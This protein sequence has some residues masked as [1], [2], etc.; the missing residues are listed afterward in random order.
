MGLCQRNVFCEQPPRPRATYKCGLVC[1]KHVLKTGTSHYILQILWAVITCPCPWCLLPRACLYIYSTSALEN[2]SQMNISLTP[3]I[4]HVLNALTI[5][6]NKLTYWSQAWGRL[7]VLGFSQCSKAFL[8]KMILFTLSG[9][10]DTRQLHHV[11]S[12]AWS[13]DRDQG[14]KKCA[15]A[16]TMT[17]EANTYEWHHLSSTTVTMVF[18]SARSGDGRL[19]TH[20]SPNTAS[21][22]PIS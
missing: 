19:L 4:Q 6:K 1:Q 15:L 8:K 3:F 13:P 17:W 9:P 12:Q 21:R 10:V 18:G 20:C 7:N 11:R 16:T 14:L 2:G 5:F 22:R